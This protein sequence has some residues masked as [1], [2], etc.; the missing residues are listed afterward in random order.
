MAVS[1]LGGAGD[2]PEIRSFRV[3]IPAL[4]AFPT[5]DFVVDTILISQVSKVLGKSE[6]AVLV[7]FVVGLYFIC[8]FK[9]L[10]SI[11]SGFS[12]RHKPSPPI[13][14]VSMGVL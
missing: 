10:Y 11:H 12:P 8:P 6:F 4:L 2:T 5:V 7:C 3:L 14:M 1:G 9:K 13:S